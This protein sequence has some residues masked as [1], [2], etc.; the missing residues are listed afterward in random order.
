MFI[1]QGNS[2][3]KV[4]PMAQHDHVHVSKKHTSKVETQ[5]EMS[6]DKSYQNGEKQSRKEFGCWQ[7]VGNAQ[8]ILIYTC[9][10][11]T[12]SSMPVVWQNFV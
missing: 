8:K 10:V 7:S 1:V 3:L 11:P 6:S 4:H 5:T 12:P 9:M 2:Q